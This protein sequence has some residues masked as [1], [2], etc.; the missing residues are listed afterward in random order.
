M[1]TDD[2]G[3]VIV[4][5]AMLEWMQYMADQT[6]LQTEILKAEFSSD[7]TLEDIAEDE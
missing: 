3:D 1:P 6:A 2:N 4:E 5:R 7:L